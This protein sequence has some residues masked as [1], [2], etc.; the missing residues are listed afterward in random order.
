MASEHNPAAHD[1]QNNSRTVISGEIIKI[2][3]KDQE[4]VDHRDRPHDQ[5]PEK[6]KKRVV[7]AASVRGAK[8][9]WV[10]LRFNVLP[11]IIQTWIE[12]HKK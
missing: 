10:G 5:Y 7:R 1:L 9:T 3:R 12:Q 8:L 4:T 6:F 2:D 11:E